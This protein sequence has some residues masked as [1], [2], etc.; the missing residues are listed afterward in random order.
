MAQQLWVDSGKQK[1]LKDIAVELD[2]SEWW[3]RK[4]KN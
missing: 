1:K 4:W 3:V 2:V